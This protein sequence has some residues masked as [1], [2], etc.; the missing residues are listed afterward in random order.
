M[1]LVPMHNRK[2]R[3]TPTEQVFDTAEYHAVAS[4]GFNNLFKGAAVAALTGSR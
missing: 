4:K 2:S 3:V 1:Q